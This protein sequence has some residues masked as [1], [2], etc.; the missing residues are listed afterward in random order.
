MADF[1]ASAQISLDAA[2][3]RRIEEF[4]TLPFLGHEWRNRRGTSFWDTVL[5]LLA[6]VHEQDFRRFCTESHSELLGSFLW[7]EAH[8]ME[9]WS[10]GAAHR[11]K[12]RTGNEAN[13]TTWTA[14]KEQSQHCFDSLPLLCEV[15]KPDAAVILTAHVP[16]DYWGNALEW[17]KPVNLVRRAIIPE[18]GTTILHAKHP[19]WVA[20]RLGQIEYDRMIA[21]LGEQIKKIAT[22]RVARQL[23]P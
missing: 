21:T 19:S 6:L 3:L 1:V 9:L 10:G 4:R 8:S 17:S 13:K 15:F 23:Q 11:W 5:K 18:T 22:G 20:R 7:A 12:Q 14:L 16:N 2:H